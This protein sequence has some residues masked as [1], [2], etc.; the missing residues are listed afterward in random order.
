MQLL[1]RDVMSTN[2]IKLKK[3]T[4]IGEAAQTFLNRSIDGA[5][6]I[7]DKNRVVGIFTKTHL[8]RAMAIGTPLNIHVERVMSRNIITINEKMLAEEALSI[9][10]GRLPVVDDAGDLVGWLTRTDLA[11]AFSAAYK[12]LMENL[13][14]ALNMTRVGLVTVDVEGRIVIYN[15]ATEEILGIPP[16]KTL[17]GQPMELVLP[18]LKMMSQVLNTGSPSSEKL[19]LNKSTFALQY[20]PIIIEEQVTGGV[21]MFQ[22]ITSLLK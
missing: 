4:T 16:G 2:I 6:I 9:P 22:D 3:S 5:P 15:Q 20:S 13:L 12:P 14:P 8:I 10:V 18:G 7:D 1:V 11:N 21:A 17:I 19:D